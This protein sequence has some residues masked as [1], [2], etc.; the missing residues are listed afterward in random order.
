MAVPGLSVVRSVLGG[1]GL[2]RVR[3]RTYLWF[4]GGCG[5]R[6]VLWGQLTG[7]VTL[8]RQWV[9]QQ[10]LDVGG[11]RT[12]NFQRVCRGPRHTGLRV[13]GFLV[14]AGLTGL[15]SLA[16]LTSLVLVVRPG[17]AACG[18]LIA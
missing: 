13:P 1:A 7:G 12:V 4:G 17:S 18:G 9:G 5:R 15:R 11:V 16:G 8:F 2:V 10:T 14:L 3:V 6:A